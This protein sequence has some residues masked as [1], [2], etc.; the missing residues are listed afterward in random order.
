MFITEMKNNPTFKHF[1][2][3]A[4]KIMLKITASV[5]TA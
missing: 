4:E 2:L 3:I 5:E 1:S